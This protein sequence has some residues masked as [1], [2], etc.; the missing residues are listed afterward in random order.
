METQSNQTNQLNVEAIYE[1]AHWHVNTGEQVIHAKR[2]PGR[3]RNIK[4][5]V[6]FFGP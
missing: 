1:E 2:M 6:F 3:F 4:W 5:F